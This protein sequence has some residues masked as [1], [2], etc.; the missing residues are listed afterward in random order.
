MLVALEPLIQAGWLSRS[1]TIPLPAARADRVEY[2]SMLPWKSDLLNLAAARMLDS[3]GEAADFEAFAREEAYWLDDY[4]LFMDLK[5]HFDRKAREEGKEGAMWSN[6]WPRE[7]A[8][9]DAGTLE[10]WTGS[11]ARSIRIRKAVQY[12]FFSQWRKLK[13]YANG[14]GVRIIGDLPIFV[15]SDSVDVWAHRDLFLLDADGAPRE[16]AGVP[17]D[18]FSATGQLWGNPLYAWEKHAANGFRWWIDRIRGNL[19]LVDWLRIDH[20]R[21]FESFW[22]V[23]SGDST[24]VGGV[25]K[26]APGSK[27][28]TALRRELGELP[29]LA[30]DLG[31]I[32]EE[33]RNLR[34]SFALP[35]MKIL[36]FAFDAKESGEGLNTRNGFLPHMYERNCV[37]YTGTHDNDTLAGWLAKAT[38]EELAFIRS[39]LGGEN[40]EGLLW[41]LIRLAYASVADFCV[42]PMQD[43]LGLGSEARM[44]TPSTIGGNWTWRLAA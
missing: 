8:L 6:Y 40:G 41:R 12:F 35:G 27:F 5:E 24:A 42:I 7:Y 43:V 44:N 20:F 15:A 33:V 10:A 26:K 1:E 38:G 11:H 14:R 39:Y 9:R 4:A 23:P 13:A 28:F 31:F 37:V 25:W 21:G 16:V 19:R 34:D 32:T 2:G 22:A 36:Q 30:E 17:P 18:Y 3:G 29:I